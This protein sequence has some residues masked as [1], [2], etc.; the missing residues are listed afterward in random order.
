[1]TPR[2]LRNI[3][4]TGNSCKDLLSCV[5]IALKLPHYFYLLMEKPLGC[6][7]QVRSTYYQMAQCNQKTPIPVSPR[8]HVRTEKAKKKISMNTNHSYHSFHLLRPVSTDLT[9]KPDS[10]LSNPIGKDGVWRVLEKWWTML[11]I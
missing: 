8:W 9:I 11:L 4:T 10:V 2:D 1:M 7:I 6:Y 3:H 5:D